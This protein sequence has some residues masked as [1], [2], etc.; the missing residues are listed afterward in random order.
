MARFKIKCSFEKCEKQ[1]LTKTHLD[2]HTMTHTNAMH[3][4]A[5]GGTFKAHLKTHIGGNSVDKRK[6]KTF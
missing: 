1:Y 3:A 5:I 6:V 4:Y 2:R